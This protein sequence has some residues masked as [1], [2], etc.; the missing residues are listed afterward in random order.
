MGFLSSIGDFKFRHAPIK[1]AI[2]ASHSNGDGL[3][4]QG[5]RH[6]DRWSMSLIWRE[7]PMIRL[8]LSA[9]ACL[10]AFGGAANAATFTFNTDPFAGSTALTTPGRQVVGGEPSIS[11]DTSGDVLIF[12]P[13]VFSI[14]GLSFVN[15]NLDMMPPSGV[16]FIVLQV[17]DDDNNPATA[18]GAGS[19]ANLIAQKITTAGAGFFIY[20]N[21]ALNLPRLVFSTNLDDPSADLKILARFTNLAGQPGSLNGFTADNVATTPVPPAAV[22]MVTPLLL[23][24][25]GAKLKRRPRSRA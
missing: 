24:A 16:N 15:S 4:Q 11:F 2:P 23:G 22:L 9:L 7:S 8:M 21:S 25:V 12:E 10:F 5:S 18:F 19:A 20:F 13:S 3:T 6:E 17:F 14:V 1:I